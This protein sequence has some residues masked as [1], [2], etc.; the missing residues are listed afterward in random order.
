MGTCLGEPPPASGATAERASGEGERERVACTGLGR[1]ALPSTT[2]G[3]RAKLLIVVTDDLRCVFDESGLATGAGATTASFPVPGS[4]MTLPS[5]KASSPRTTTRETAPTTLV[6]AKGD[7]PHL[8]CLGTLGSSHRTS[9]ST[10]TAV[11]SWTG[12]QK[13]LRGFVWSRSTR[14]S[15][16]SLPSCTAV[17][18]RGSIVSSPG[19]P[20]G[21]PSELFSASVWGAWCEEKTSMMPMLSHSAFWST[22]VARGGCTDP[23]VPAPRRCASSSLRKRWW[24]ETPHVTLA[25]LRLA[26]RMTMISS[27]RDSAHTWIAR[28]YIMAIISTA[29]RVLL[30]ARTTMGRLD[31][32][33]SK[34]AIHTVRSSICSVEHVAWSSSM[35]S[36]TAPSPTALTAS[37][38]PIVAPTHS[39]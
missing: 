4:A 21:A 5:R 29:A 18:R 2:A 20:G 30:S 15:T 24:G 35:L 7:H 19:K 14:S 38:L 10:S 17:R 13:I 6:P 9:R 31:G 32:H 36:P 25:P 26:S 11:S 1:A 12:R 3:G 39:A 8:E 22:L 37:M 34:C 16:V 23:K 28:S 33:V 27:R